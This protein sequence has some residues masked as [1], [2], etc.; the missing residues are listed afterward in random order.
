MADRLPPTPG[1]FDPL[2]GASLEPSDL[3]ISARQRRLWNL[4]QHT[5]TSL[6][7]LYKCK[8]SK[9]QSDNPTQDQEWQESW[10]A[11]QSAAS[12]LTSLYRESAEILA[13]LEKPSSRVS[14]STITSSELSLASPLRGN[15]ATVISAS[16]P[17]SEITNYTPSSK[18]PANTD[19]KEEEMVTNSTTN[20][21]QYD[22]LNCSSRFKRSW[23][24]WEDDDMDHFGGAKRRKFL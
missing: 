22:F 21:P 17:K 2:K 18:P 8:S 5:A 6:T 24:P 12:S 11:F 1:D 14:P 10:L 16:S 9:S 23:S 7:H 4:F 20:Q 3:E 15:N 13:S 19:D